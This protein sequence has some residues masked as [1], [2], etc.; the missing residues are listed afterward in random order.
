MSPSAAPGRERRST[1]SSRTAS[2]SSA[3]PRQIDV[4]R[5]VVVDEDARAARASSEATA[6]PM[7]RRR[8]TPVTRAVLPRRERAGRRRGCHAVPFAIGRRGQRRAESPA[9]GRGVR[10]TNLGRR[11]ATAP[12]GRPPTSQSAGLAHARPDVGGRGYCGPG[13]HPAGDPVRRPRVGSR[14]PRSAARIRR[15]AVRRTVRRPAGSAAAGLAVRRLSAPAPRV[16]R[17]PA[18]ATSPAPIRARCCTRSTATTRSAASRAR[19]STT[20]SRAATRS[21]SCPPV[22]ARA[23]ATRCRRSCARA[24]GSS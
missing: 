10:V 15:A 9:C 8:E 3:A 18:S 5:P 7:P 11:R 16:R 1:S 13:E 22:P 12:P 17:R 14:R 23:S 20:S 2:R 19:S 6:K 4:V 24:R 21:C